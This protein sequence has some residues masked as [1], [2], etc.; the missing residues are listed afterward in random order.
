LRREGDGPQQKKKAR[1]LSSRAFYLYFHYSLQQKIASQMISRSG[2]CGMSYLT[3]AQDGYQLTGAARN[4][5]DRRNPILIGLFMHLVL[6]GPANW[7][8]GLLFD[9]T[10]GWGCCPERIDIH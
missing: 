3:V 1:Q 10:A 5:A 8:R 4:R 9:Y 7:R 2:A 6:R